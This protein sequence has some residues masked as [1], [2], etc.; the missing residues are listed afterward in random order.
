MAS[1]PL[2]RRPARNL[3][4]SATLQLNFH[5]YASQLSIPSFVSTEDGLTYFSLV[6]ERDY[7]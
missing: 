5:C 6:I 7:Y 4:C 2:A 1:E 3:A